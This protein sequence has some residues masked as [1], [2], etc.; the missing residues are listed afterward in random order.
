MLYIYMIIYVLY[1]LQ[2]FYASQ[3]AGYTKMVL[4]WSL[5]DL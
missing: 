1:E 2:M 4:R 3:P 5:V